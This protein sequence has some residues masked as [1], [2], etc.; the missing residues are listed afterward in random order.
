[1]IIVYINCRLFPFITWIISGLK[2]YETRNRNTLKSLVGKTVYIAETGHNKPPVIRCKCT[3]G[4]PVIVTDKQTY[5]RYR[6]HTCIE[7]GS[8]F[9][10]TAATKKKVLY[11][12]LNVQE[13]K[14]FTVPENVIRHGRTYCE[15]I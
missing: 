1:M 6:K 4:E 8:V 3:I 10:F 13:V 7:K 5:N 2:T 15:I 9:D 11:P 12:L 14:P